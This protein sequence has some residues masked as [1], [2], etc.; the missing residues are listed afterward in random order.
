MPRALWLA[1][2]LRAAGLPVQEVTGWQTRGS[3]SF[4]PLGV[5]VHHT[6]AP[7]GKVAPSLTVVVNGREGLSGPLCQVLI[8]RN[9]IVHVIAAGRAN[10]A[11]TGGP[12]P[13]VPV[14]LGNHHLIGIEAEHDGRNEPWTPRMIDTMHMATAAILTRL[15][16]PAA[17]CWGHKEWAPTRKPDPVGI[18]MDQFR[19]AVAHYMTGDTVPSI[20]QENAQRIL[21]AWL[22]E[23]RRILADGDWQ[24]AETLALKYLLDESLGPAL[25]EYETSTRN[26]RAEVDTHRA[27]IRNLRDT[28]ARLEAGGAAPA[29]LQVAALV[30]IG[31]KTLE[32]VDTV[33]AESAK[34]GL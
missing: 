16:K 11:G 31:R 32:W 24:E 20:H 17:H 25:T 18:D 15:G 22:P 29:D 23:V 30:A 6:A 5:L 13:D 4:A 19:A 2:N 28:I 26:L 3:D 10:H 1:D 12:L 8:D 7:Q 33:T 34:H 27:E 21:N 14:N 9:A